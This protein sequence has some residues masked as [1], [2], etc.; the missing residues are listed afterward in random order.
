VDILDG[1]SRFL[2][3]WSLN[4]TQGAE[5]VTL[6]VQQALDGLAAVS[7]IDPRPWGAVPERGV[8]AVCDRGWAGGRQDPGRSPRVQRAAGAPAPDGSR[9][10]RGR[11]GPERL[12]AVDALARWS[13]YYNHQRPHSAMSYMPP[14]V[15]YCGDPQA[16]WAERRRK[17]AHAA[18]ARKAYCKGVGHAR[19]DHSHN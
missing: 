7:G 15:Y 12:R 19:L 13:H 16:R 9:R 14:M 18:Q 11:P 3:H 4:R 10:R 5:A 1:Y 2:V 8:V 17:L 6:T